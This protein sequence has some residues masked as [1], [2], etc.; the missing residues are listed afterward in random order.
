MDEFMTTFR[1][2]ADNTG[3]I[4]KPGQTFQL[5]LHL[6]GATVW[7]AGRIVQLQQPLVQGEYGEEKKSS[8]FHDE[9]GQRRL[10]G[11]LPTKPSGW[12]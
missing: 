1:N 12:W 4:F 3:G 10:Q 5:E 6:H 9:E 2:M 11:A 8:S 7:V